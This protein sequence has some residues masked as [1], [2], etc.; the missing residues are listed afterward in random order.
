MSWV[1]CLGKTCSRP[2][3]GQLEGACRVLRTD[4]SL[5]GEGAQVNGGGIGLG[6]QGARCPPPRPPPGAAPPPRPAP[7]RGAGGPPRAG[8]RERH[9]ATLARRIVA[10]ESPITKGHQPR[11]TRAN[12][13]EIWSI[14]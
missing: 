11:G 7:P 4:S 10:T 2:R 9:Y 14:P 1:V 8:G 6:Q 3:A 12:P 5:P 13:E